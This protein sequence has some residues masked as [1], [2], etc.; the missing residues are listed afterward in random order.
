ML[1]KG[2]QCPRCRHIL[3]NWEMPDAY[4]VEIID[5]RERLVPGPVFL[6]PHCE[7]CGVQ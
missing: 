7:C 6:C 2:I 1:T 4:A 3:N 5:G